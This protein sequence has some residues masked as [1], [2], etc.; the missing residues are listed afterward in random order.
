MSLLSDFRL[1]VHENN[2]GVYGIHIH[3]D[4]HTIAEHRFRSNDRENLYSASKAF[5]GIGIGIAIDQGLLNLNDKVLSFFPEFEC[6]ASKGSELISIENLLMMSSGHDS[7]DWS[8]FHTM[9]RAKL[10]FMSEVINEPGKIFFYEDL[11]SYMLGRVIEK[12]TNMTMLAY[13]KIHLFGKLNIINPQWHTCNNGHTACSGGLYLTTEEFSRLGVLMLNKGLYNDKRVVSEEYIKK[14]ISKGLDTSFK[15]DSES[16]QGYGYHLWHCTKKNT[17]RADGMYRQACV[18]LK[19][20]N[21]VVTYTGH[22]EEYGNDTLRAV[23]QDILPQ[24]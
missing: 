18:V 8:K 9:D 19:D 15:L 5:V 4:G 16:Q 20:Y 12:L 14:M 11:C 10:F 21:A 17:Y 13:L 23:W 1:S 3:Q 7:E 24:L 22:N 6:I 2:L